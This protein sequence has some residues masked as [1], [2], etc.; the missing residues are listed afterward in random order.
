MKGFRSLA[1]PFWSILIAIVLWVQVHGAGM[2]SLRMD[3]SLQVRDVPTDMVIVNDLPEQVSITITGLQTQLNALD[4]KNLFVSVD[5]SVL[6]KPGVIEQALDVS[7]ITLPVGLK[8]EKIQPDSVQ[9]QV[10]HVVT[11]S[12]DV[13]PNFN[14]PQGWEAIQVVVTPA[15]VKLTGPEVWLST[16]NKIETAAIRLDQASGLFDVSTSLVALSGKGIHVQ[17]SDGTV[18]VRGELVLK[19]AEEPEP[20]NIEDVTR[21]Q[22]PE[23]E[24]ADVPTAVKS[25]DKTPEPGAVN[26]KVAV[27]VDALDTYAEDIPAEAIVDAQQEEIDALTSSVEDRESDSFPE[28]ILAA[29]TVEEALPVEDVYARPATPIQE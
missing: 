4:S 15:V 20:V 28:D 26:A 12:L 3:V 8:V 29:P 11:R 18:R 1:L 5:A 10:D 17:G 25:I 2:G 13:Q 16:L 19:K 21:A 9:L 22:A 24:L 27:D 7:K 23:T 14:L 6:K